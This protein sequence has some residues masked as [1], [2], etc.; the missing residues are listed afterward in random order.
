MFRNRIHTA[1]SSA[2]NDNGDFSAMRLATE[3]ANILQVATHL[4]GAISVHFIT[5]SVL[6]IRP[7]DRRD[8]LAA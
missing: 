6:I 3:A 2:Y 7:A 1:T 8:R 5:E 4:A